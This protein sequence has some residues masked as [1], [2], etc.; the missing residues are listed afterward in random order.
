MSLDVVGADGTLRTY[1]RGTTPT[2]TWKALTTHLGLL[3]VVVRARLKVEPQFNLH[4][5]VTYQDEAR[6]FDGT[7]GASFID[8]VK[9]CDFGQLQWF[10]GV[11]RFVRTCGTRTTE[12]AEPGA[13][14]V[15]LNPDIADSLKAPLQGLL[16][17]AACD[18]ESGFLDFVEEFRF[19]QIYT[20]PPFVKTVN[21]AL[22]ATSDVIGPSHRMLGSSLLAAQQGFFQMDW[23]VAVPETRMNDAMAYIR[24]FVDGQNARNRMIRLPLVGMFLRFAR[25]EDQ[26]LMAYEGTGGPF[27]E[28]Q[29]VVHVEMPI[30]VPVGFSAAQLEDYMSPFR[31]YVTTLINTYGGRG[32]WGKNRDFIFPLQVANGSL[33][34]GG[35]LTRFRN[36][37]RTLDPH[38]MFANALSTELGIVY[39]QPW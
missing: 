36:V 3:G 19:A 23:E 35:R 29:Y 38:G 39:P 14:N 8:V 24:R 15:L 25:I 17:A 32:H 5:A 34:Y 2:D 37:V 27:V 30:Y 6:L 12:A 26:T 21:G 18:S 22:H 1:S 10:P 28:G 9:E 11:G 16:Q 13:R 7:Y 4:V 31:E 33:D 20:T